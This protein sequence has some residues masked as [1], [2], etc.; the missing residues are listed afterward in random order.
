MLFDGQSEK[1][2]KIFPALPKEWENSSAGVS[3]QKFLANGGIEV[4][5]RYYSNRVDVTLNNTSNESITRTL[6]VRIPSTFT[7]ISEKGGTPIEGIVKDRFAKMTINVA[8]NSVKALTITGI[9]GNEWYS[10]DDSVAIF[11]TGWT[12]TANAAFYDSASHVSNTGGSS[13]EYKFTGNAVRILGQLGPDR[14]YARVTLD[15]VNLGCYN[16]YGSYAQ[17]Q[18][19]LFEK[20]NLGP[21]P[22]SIKWEVTGQKIQISKN[23]FVDI[24]KIEVLMSGNKNL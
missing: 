8:G 21:G 15:G 18:K 4:S 1:T 16:L 5:G 17:P 6:L 7:K 19:V 11:S 13:C 23:A 12:K 2:I 10:I 3:F 20:F 9:Q 24:D 14:G 22:H